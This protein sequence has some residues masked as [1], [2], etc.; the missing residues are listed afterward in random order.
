MRVLF[1]QGA[2]M[3]GRRGL[4]VAGLIGVM[5]SASVAY[6]QRIWIGGGM[7]AR[8]A[9][10]EDFDGQFLYCRGFFRGGWTTDYPGADNNFSVRLMELTM[11]PVKLDPDRQP[12]HVVVRFDSP[13]LFRCPLLFMENVGTIVQFSDDEVI[14]LRTYLQKGGFLWVDDFWGSAAWD[15]WALEFSR[16]LPPSEYPVFDIPI[17]HPIMHTLFDVKEFLQVSSISFWYRS[18]GQVSERGYD[19]AEV[20]YRGVQDSRGNLMALMTHNT[21]VADTWEREGEN[22]EYFNMFSPRGYAIGVNVVLYAL[23]H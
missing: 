17:S 7:A 9:Q 19:S 6:A 20:H 5:A 10:R 4:V 11:I 18:G 12:H 8:F 2:G 21:D 16:V 22:G 3:R 1:K 13:V 14:G 23:T 15:R